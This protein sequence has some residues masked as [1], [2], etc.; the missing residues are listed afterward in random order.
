[1]N[2]PVTLREA[3]ELERLS[4][5]NIRVALLLGVVV[6][7]ALFSTFYFWSGVTIPT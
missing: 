6:L 2:Q 3:E 1:M 7:L 4:R 5:S